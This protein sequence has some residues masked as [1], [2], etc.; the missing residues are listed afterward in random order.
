MQ[1]KPGAAHECR[2]RLKEAIMARL[3][4]AIALIAAMGTAPVSSRALTADTRC[5]ETD[6]ALSQRLRNVVARDEFGAPRSASLNLVMARMASA[7]F[8][9][10]HGHAERGL[11]AYGDADEALQVVEEQA[12]ARTARSGAADRVH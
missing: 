12:L 3:I 4:T 8:D 10:K 5:I 7:R 6:Q 9:C 1:D 11:R 2:D